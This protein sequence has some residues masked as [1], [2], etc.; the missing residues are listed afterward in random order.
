MKKPPSVGLFLCPYL[1]FTTPAYIITLV[2]FIQEKRM[3][4]K[5]IYKIMGPI[6]LASQ[7]S[8]CRLH[9]EALRFI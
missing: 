5:F 1:T 7:K 8:T 3:K 4:G 9:Y 6:Y 2:S